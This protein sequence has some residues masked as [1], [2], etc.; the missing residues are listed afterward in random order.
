VGEWQADVELIVS[1]CRAYNH[2]TSGIVAAAK[3]F[4]LLVA[5]LCSGP[6]FAAASA[7]AAGAGEEGGREMLP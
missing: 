5:G 7:A 3:K 4:E 6:L 1:N 2:P